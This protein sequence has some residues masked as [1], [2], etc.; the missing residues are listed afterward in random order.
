MLDEMNSKLALAAGM[1]ERLGQVPGVVAVTLGGS[2]ARR[3][4]H[5]DSD[6]DLGLYYHPERRPAHEALQAIAQELGGSANSV[7][8]VGAWGPWINGGAWLTVRGQR[9]DWLSRDLTLVEQVLGQAQQGLAER[10][11]QPGH[12][13]GFH[14]HIY[15][16]EVHY[17]HLLSDSER[18]LAR[19]Q[20]RLKQYP[21]KLKSSLTVSYLWQ[22][23]FALDVCEKS[24]SRGESSYVAG[25][26]FESIYCLVQVIYALNE[27]YFVNEK[28]AVAETRAFSICP[29]GF[30]DDV[31]D[32]LGQ[33][34]KD[35]VAL[36]V[37][38]ARVQ[39]L[40]DKVQQLAG[41]V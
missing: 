39:G 8:A 31:T 20:E 25:C 40:V 17:S 11:V 14:S 27:R 1:G 16:A 6:I 5:P 34:G 2:L 41:E 33:P 7:T 37:S 13:H 21:Q 35:A 23:Q 32:V 18:E 24:V 10:Y 29:P 9:V 22:A 26:L 28:G 36:G 38:L 3:Q 30:A 12:P 19:L 15:L 4:G